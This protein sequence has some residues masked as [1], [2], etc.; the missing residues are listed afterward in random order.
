[1]DVN[2]ALTVLSRN[3]TAAG[4][5]LAALALGLARD[6]YP[7]LDVAGYLSELDAMGKELR[8]KMRGALPT[9]VE[10]LCRY[11]FHDLGFRG[12]E[13]DYYDPRN[14]YFNEVLDR[15]TGLPITLSLTAMA[16]GKRAGMEVVGV[17]LPGHFVAKAVDERGSVLFDPFHGGRRLTAA[18]CERLAEEASGRP[19]RASAPALRAVPAGALVLRLL[20]N[21]KAVYL[22]SGDFSRAAR[23]IGRLRQLNPDDALQQRDLGATLLQAGQAG[24]AIDHLAEYLRRTPEADDLETVRQLLSRARGMVARWN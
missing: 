3:P 22:R 20:T 9:R 19:F 12:N 15:R 4:L 7:D 6:E 21:L 23:I 8:P 24:K 14:S 13:R 10:S 5:D 2:K 11:L 1:M 17:G 16:V 18:D